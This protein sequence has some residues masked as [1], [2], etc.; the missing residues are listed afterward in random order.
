MDRAGDV[1]LILGLTRSPLQ[2]DFLTL[3]ASFSYIMVLFEMDLFGLVLKMIFADSD[4]FLCVAKYQF[5]CLNLLCLYSFSFKLFSG[6]VMSCEEFSDELI[7][8]FLLLVGP[9][10]NLD[11][12]LYDFK[13][14]RQ[15][16][17]CFLWASSL[18]Y[19]WLC[20]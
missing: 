16:G 14:L 10:D 17:Y 6:L 5:G 7:E 4:S 11:F 19:S 3:F 8:Q 12:I 13:N 18:K 9:Q 20:M 2:R 15:E 1:I